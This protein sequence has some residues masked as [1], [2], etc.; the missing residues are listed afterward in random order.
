MYDE[1]RYRGGV[2]QRIRA[3]G[4]Y[5]SGRRF[6]SCR[7]HIYNG[8][9]MYQNFKNLVVAYREGVISRKIFIMEWSKLQEA[10]NVAMGQ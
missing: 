2:A 3:G 1:L 4:F 8:G 9:I 6:E 5:P 10:E 7:H